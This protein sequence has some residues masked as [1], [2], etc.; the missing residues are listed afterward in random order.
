ML[1]FEGIKQQP[2]WSDLHYYGKMQHVKQFATLRLVKYEEETAAKA[3]AP[4][5]IY[6]LHIRTDTQPCIFNLDSSAKCRSVSNFSCNIH[7]NQL[8]ISKLRQRKIPA[9]A[10]CNRMSV[11]PMLFAPKA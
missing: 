5:T 9:A 4:T 10:V 3:K 2:A 1:F 11:P 7:V 8:V 6:S